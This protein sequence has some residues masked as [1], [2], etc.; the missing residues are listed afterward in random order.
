MHIQSGSPAWKNEN[1]RG[2]DESLVGCGI[3][4]WWPLDRK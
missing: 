2:G 1:D 3:K 4:V